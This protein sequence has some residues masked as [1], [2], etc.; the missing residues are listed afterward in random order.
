MMR[1]LYPGRPSR[2]HIPESVSMRMVDHELPSARGL[3]ARTN[4]HGGSK[5]RE[6]YQPK[7][8]AALPFIETISQLHAAALTYIPNQAKP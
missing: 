2:F 1:L 5:F 8:H 4:I 3:L 7:A 6:G